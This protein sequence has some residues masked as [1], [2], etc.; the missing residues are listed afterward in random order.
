MFLSKFRLLKSY[1]KLAW[2]LLRLVS[3][4]E[5]T[6]RVFDIGEALKDLGKFQHAYLQILN[7]PEYM[8]VIRQRKLMQSYSLLDLRKLPEGSLGR[9]Y[10]EHMIKNNLDPEFYRSLE[11]KTDLDYIILRQR[12]TH[13]WWHI[14]TG[15]DTSI[16]GEISLQTV[17]ATQTGLPIHTMLIALGFLRV[18]LKDMA[19][20]PQLLEAVNKGYQLGKKSKSLFIYDWEKNWSKPLADVRI[21]LNIQ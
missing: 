13:D 20:L 12:Q 11:I 21:E 9:T 14:A 4:P 3:N 17:Y 1:G 18:A 7:R 15:F 16:A 8:D 19:L 5:D 6:D 10:A 2:G